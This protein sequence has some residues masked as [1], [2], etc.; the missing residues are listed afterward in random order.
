ML[1]TVDPGTGISKSCGYVFS[2]SFVSSRIEIY[3]LLI[4]R[5]LTIKISESLCTN[6]KLI[7]EIEYL[8]FG[9]LKQRCQQK[10]RIPR[11]KYFNKL[12]KDYKLQFVISS[13]HVN[14]ILFA[15]QL[16]ELLPLTREAK[17]V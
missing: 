5:L 10:V 9:R 7:F 3:S 13:R 15:R 6:R 8:I 16:K 11:E 12:K 4:I 2:K 1:L 14:Q 17:F